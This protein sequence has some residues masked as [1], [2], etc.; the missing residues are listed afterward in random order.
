ML[1]R[2]QR[3]SMRAYTQ[4]EATRLR[5]V[6]WVKNTPNNTVVGEVAGPQPAVDELMTWLRTTG[7]PKSRVDEMNIVEEVVGEE[8]TAVRISTFP[9]PAGFVVDKSFGWA[10]KGNKKKKR[11]LD[12]TD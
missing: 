7:S 5:L 6:G 3:V 2:V 11:H 8:D 9:D 1:G 12:Q 10:K 4:R